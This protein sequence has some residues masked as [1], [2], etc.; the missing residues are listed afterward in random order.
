MTETVKD[1]KAR[2][3]AIPP[4]N[5][6]TRVIPGLAVRKFVVSPRQV[7]VVIPTLNEELGIG[8]VIDEVR[9]AGFTNILVVDGG[10]ADRTIEIA[11]EHGANVVLQEG[12]GKT[13]AIE[14]ATGFVSTDYFVVMDGDWTY[15]AS[16]IQAMVDLLDHNDEVIGWRHYGRK[17]IPFFNRLGNRLLSR[18][19]GLLFNVK[20]HDICSGMY[21]I[22]TS[23]AD[24]LFYESGGFS[25]EVELAAQVASSAGH[26]AE[27]PIEYRERKGNNKMN[28]Y[29]DGPRI[30]YDIVKLSWTYSPIFSLAFASSLM[31]VPGVVLGAWVALTY[32][33]TG[34]EHFVWAMISAGLLGGGI[35]AFSTALLS[36]QLKRSEIRQRR[37][38]RLFLERSGK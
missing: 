18:Q 5:K 15:P 7:T 21:A 1:V 11:D 28:P 24:E 31:L 3:Q 26:I 38:N 6:L 8:D 27:I 4:P 9:A 2:G 35:P 34:V 37:M 14:S 29:R 30:A 10:S 32:L 33:F 13:K 36:L 16:H 20:V 17:N 22:K 25:T 12:R 19:F 23:F